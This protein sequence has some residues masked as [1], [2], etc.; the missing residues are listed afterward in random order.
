M[1]GDM[2]GSIMPS[3]SSHNNEVSQGALTQMNLP[4]H[5]VVTDITGTTGMGKNV[6]KNGTLL[7]C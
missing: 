3:F 4:L 7:K 6:G 2:Y 5:H 1:Y